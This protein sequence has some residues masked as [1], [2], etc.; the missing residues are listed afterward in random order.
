MQ[1]MGNNVMKWEQIVFLDAM[2]T[3]QGKHLQIRIV[4]A[5]FTEVLSLRKVF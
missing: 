2:E 4:K 5:T 3:E 1:Y